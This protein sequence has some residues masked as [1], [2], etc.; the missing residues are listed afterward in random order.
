[1]GET[2]ASRAD[3]VRMQDLVLMQQARL[4]RIS[5]RGSRRQSAAAL[6]TLFLDLQTVLQ[7]A[8]TLEIGALFAQFS[9]EMSR[10]GIEAHAFEANPYTHDAFVRRLARRAPALNYHH[11][12]ISDADG[13]ATFQIR[14]AASG[15]TMRKATNNSLL[16]RENPQ[17]E[18]ETVTVPAS[19]LD[20]FL[21]GTGLGD[22]PYSAWI[23]VEGAL[24]KVT[25]GFG[26]ALRS[27]LSLIVEVEEKRFWQDQM[28]VHDVMDYMDGQGMV[29][30]ARDFEY[31]HQYNL[32]YLR[33]DVFARS[34]V[35]MVLSRYLSTSHIAGA[36]AVP[37]VQAGAEDA[38]D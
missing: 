28:L 29:P 3:L 11:M 9:Q 16:T 34:D 30:V 15:R 32:L 35:R 8:L 17:T 33:K 25:A 31:R 37:P 2:A 22:R 38:L 13:E 27:C 26:T 12:A 18:Y 21:A 14:R 20:S 5:D 1:M 23:D 24:S 10:R 36:T 7:P 4:H 19:R 6:Q